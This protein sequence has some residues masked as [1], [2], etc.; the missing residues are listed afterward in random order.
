MACDGT[1]L[2]ECCQSL[3]GM[4]YQVV[5]V[6]IDRSFRVPSMLSAADDALAEAMAV[7]GE[8]E[9]PGEWSSTIDIAMADGVPRFEQTYRFPGQFISQI[10]AWQYVFVD[11]TWP[12]RLP[13]YNTPGLT[14]VTA[15]ARKVKVL[16]P[17]YL[18]TVYKA[19]GEY[20]ECE[21]YGETG[22]TYEITL[23]PKGTPLSGFQPLNR[24]IYEANHWALWSAGGQPSCI[25]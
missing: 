10:S 19:N 16:A 12:G 25:V 4:L 3:E 14:L 20:T 5:A 6:R 11:G 8:T 13:D 1:Y 22:G 24:R 15:H 21:R 7:M 9:F 18:T 2:G 23:T 17:R